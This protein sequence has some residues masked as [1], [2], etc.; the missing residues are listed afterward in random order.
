M[1]K[2]TWLVSLCCLATTT[3]AQAQIT[4][5][6]TLST[7]VTTSDNRNFTISGGSS[8]GGNLFH[9]FSE[10]SVPT[11][12]TAA[13][14]NVLDVQNIISRVTGSSTSNIDGLI[15]ANGSANLFLLNPNG[16]IF[17]SN[18]QL[19]IGG[20]FLA[21]TATRLNFADGSFFSATDLPAEPLLNINVPVGLQ[22]GE[23]VGQ[24]VYQGVVEDVGGFPVGGLRVQAGK[25]IALVGGNVLLEG[26]TLVAPGGRIEL[27]SVA[28][29]SLVSLTPIT[30]GWDLEYEEVQNFQDIQ[31]SSASIYVGYVGGEN[32]GDIDLRGRQIA[33]ADGS[34]VGGNNFSAN[35]GGNLAVKAAE[36]VDVSGGSVL[37][38][39]TFASG[40]AGEIN[41]ETKQLLIRDGSIIDTL[42]NGDGR[43][44]NIT[45]NASESLEVIGNR[46]FTPITSRT[47]AAGDA[48]DIKVTTGRLALRDGG[49][50]ASST[51]D[52]GNGGVVIVDASESIEAS[53]QGE[54]AVGRVEA[55]GLLSETA[56]QSATGNGG[57]LKINTG[58]LVVQAGADISVAAVEGS[59]GQAGTL[60]INA[61][62]SIEVSGIGSNLLAESESPESAGNITIITDK[63]IVSDAAEVNVDSQGSG[64]AGNLEI[65]ASSIRLDN[66]GK[67]TAVSSGEGGG[68]ISLQNLDLLLL[69]SNSEIATDATAGSGDGGNININTNLL[70]GLENSD[71]T[72]TAI[73]G[74]GGNIQI[75]TQGIFGIEPR[76]DRTPLSDITA[77]SRLGV[78]GVVR[79]NRPDVDPSNEIAILPAEIIDVSGLIA[80]GCSAGGEAIARDLSEFIITGRG[81]LP[82]TPTE[83]LRG[84]TA[85][86]DLGESSISSINR[87]EPATVASNATA[88]APLIEAQG[89]ITS[90]QGKVV[91]TA[92]T[93]GVISNVPWLRSASCE[94]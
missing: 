44:G 36:F 37:N 4:S 11:G 29:S 33:I 25:T 59:T 79:I 51:R 3:P 91:L 28:G 39:G 12:G 66:G 5:D 84:D 73:E 13:F 10:F 69:R 21:S 19:D 92:Q 80:Q 38:T 20:S 31:L 60:D 47:F 23:T 48:G 24:I 6:R 26:A 85:L 50:I 43:G 77:S 49:Q 57:S 87:A 45:I 70:I 75:N 14:N 71:I 65:T 7:Q 40:A 94:S 32:L 93:P 41:I 2:L 18:A 58:R 46:Q 52:A 9:S 15:R 35:P 17:S 27:G 81:G 68:N 76:S 88:T 34:Q 56:G 86:V 82:P 55:S 90:S 78:D 67:L 83:A 54:T 8:A 62:E 16:I 22:F 64:D 63:L 42:S 61:L 53:G 1:N 74:R 30:T 72:A 89:W